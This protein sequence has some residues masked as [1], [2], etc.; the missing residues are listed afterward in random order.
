LSQ[1]HYGLLDS[2]LFSPSNLVVE[3]LLKVTSKRAW[4]V[5]QLGVRAPHVSHSYFDDRNRRLRRFWGRS[6]YLA[7]SRRLC[8]IATLRLLRWD[9][10]L[11]RR[12]LWRYA[13]S[14]GR[15]CY[16]TLS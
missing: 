3:S 2:C 14:W 1:K 9:R 11:G 5:S 15:R 6:E 4:R 10:F 13:A 7:K 8:T 12:L 16:G